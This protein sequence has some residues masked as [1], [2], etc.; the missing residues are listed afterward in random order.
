[1]YC[2]ILLMGYTSGHFASKSM[3]L[4]NPIRISACSWFTLAITEIVLPPPESNSTTFLH[5]WHSA[6]E[7]IFSW[8]FWP[9]SCWLLFYCACQLSGWHYFDEEKTKENIL[10]GSLRGNIIAAVLCWKGYS[11]AILCNT[12]WL[13]SPPPICPLSMLSLSFKTWGGL[14]RSLE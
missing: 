1:M 9:L 6:K 4:H 2:L 12:D 10:A 3:N 14:F 13:S 8:L 5:R 7:G 11:N